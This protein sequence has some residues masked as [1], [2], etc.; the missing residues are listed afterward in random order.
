[1]KLR[2]LLAASLLLVTAAVFAVPDAAELMAR[3]ERTVKL[4][5]AR[6]ELSFELNAA[7]GTKRLR[8][9]SSLVR[10][11]PKTGD[12][13]RLA[14]FEF[15][16]DA[17]GLATLLIEH[18]G[19]DDELWVYV[20]AVKKL[21]RLVADN[22]RD[23]FMGTV[24]SHGDVLGYKAAD[25]TH[26]IV[27]E[28]EFEGHACWR[29]ISKPANEAVRKASGYSQ[30]ESWIDQQTAFN[31]RM[32]TWDEAGKPLKSIVNRRVQAVPQQPGAF[33]AYEI[34]A[35]DLQEGAST[36]MTVERFEYMPGM[37]ADEFAPTALADDN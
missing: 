22:Q 23:S 33:L 29:V 6:I 10:T 3:S 30:R 11:D 5:G 31:W 1:M 17:R 19:R 28:A 25:W 4:A 37:K 27:G 34:E 9:L 12:T 15:P 8:K 24:L 18:H 13:S 20:P 36:R 2:T 26:E 7:S 35:S 16:A 21:R 32:D 14:R